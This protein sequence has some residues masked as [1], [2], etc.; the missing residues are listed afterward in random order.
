M[1]PRQSLG[2]GLLREFEK[3]QMTA[4]PAPGNPLCEDEEWL[5]RQAGPEQ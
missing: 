3:N 5:Q 1:S 2:A 4:P